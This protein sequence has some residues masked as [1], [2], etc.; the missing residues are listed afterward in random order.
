MRKCFRKI[1]FSGNSAEIFCGDNDFDNIAGKMET[2]VQ[3]IGQ[4]PL[5]PG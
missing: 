4:D 5:Q 2:E 3:L 1:E